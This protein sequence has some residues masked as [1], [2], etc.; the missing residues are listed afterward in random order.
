MTDKV[1]LDLREQLD[2]YAGGFPSTESGVEMEILERLFSPEE[3]EMYLGLSV[4]LETPDTVAE[5]LGREPDEVAALL[6]RMTDKGL[7]Y[8]IKKGDTLKYGAV[9]FVPGSYDFQVK[10]MDTELAELCDRYF[11]EA[12]GKQ[13]IAPHPPLRPVPVNKSINYKW[14][15]APYDDVKAIIGSKDKISVA[16]CICRVRQGLLDKACQKPVEVCFQ[17]GSNAQYYVDKGMARFITHEDAFGILDR[18]EEAGLVPQPVIGEDSGALC[19]CCGDCCEILTSIKMDPKPAERVF[20][21]YYAVVDPDACAACETCVDRCQ[22]EAIK[23]GANDVAEVD[24]DR[25]IGCGL[26]VTTCPNQAVSLQLKAEPER[27]EPPATTRQFFMQ[28]ASVRGKSLVPLAVMR[29]SVT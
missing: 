14:P 21:N 26:C 2:Q 16:R 18:C 23:P 10:D 8:R 1:Y 9:P 28:L 20:S 27:R 13:A 29:K 4:M 22:M 25:C 17:F 7:I 15:V 6:E 5:R 3:A 12:L 24:R 11:E 19:N